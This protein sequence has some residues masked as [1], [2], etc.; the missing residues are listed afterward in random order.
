MVPEIDL[1]MTMRING[2]CDYMHAAVSCIQYMCGHRKPMNVPHER[3]FL[4][5]HVVEL[6]KAR[7]EVKILILLSSAPQ[8]KLQA[9]VLF[10]MTGLCQSRWDRNSVISVP[11]APWGDTHF[12]LPF[13]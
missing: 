10:P 11:V 2:R 9:F 13:L 4:L 12:L 1:L 3:F 8:V 5:Y 7:P 6:F